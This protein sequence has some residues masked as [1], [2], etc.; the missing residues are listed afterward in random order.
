MAIIAKRESSLQYRIKQEQNKLQKEHHTGTV[1]LI[2]GLAFIVLGLI[3][4]LIMP[5]LLIFNLMIGIPLCLIGLKRLRRQ[6]PLLKNLQKGVEGE[7]KVTELLQR[8][9]PDTYTIVN[10]VRLPIYNRKTQVDH[11]IIGPQGILNIETKNWQAHVKETNGR[12]FI[13]TKHKAFTKNFNPM[14]QSQYHEKAIKGMLDKYSDIPIS[15]QEKLH[16]QT[17]VVFTDPNCK[18]EMTSK[19]NHYVFR[20]DEFKQYLEFYQIRYAPLIQAE[21]RYLTDFFK[22]LHFRGERS[23]KHKEINYDSKPKPTKSTK[24]TNDCPKCGHKMVKRK[25]KHGIFLG[26]SSFPKCRHTMSV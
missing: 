25:G 3:T 6:S 10:D 1:F 5:L 16:T 7:R 14:K 18:I 19:E 12:W 15:I 2:V 24:S 23:V 9:L 13:R 20:L 11:M 22:S 8:A 17:V 4:T 26:C 21:T